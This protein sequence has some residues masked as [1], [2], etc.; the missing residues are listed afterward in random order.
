MTTKEMEF[1]VLACETSDARENGS[2]FIGDVE[3]LIA[4]MNQK[5]YDE[6]EVWHCQLALKRS[7]YIRLHANYNVED[8]DPAWSRAAPEF[9]I[10]PD[11]LQWWFI[12]KY[13]RARYSRMV[14]D[15]KRTRDECLRNGILTVAAW[16]E[17]LNMPLLLVQKIMHAERL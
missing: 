8:V 10:T 17:K 9:T 14:N 11:G 12:R 2:L 15:L 16:A 1:M 13:G 3:P 6:K 7:G 4:T 5:G